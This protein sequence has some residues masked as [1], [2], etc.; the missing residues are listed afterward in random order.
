LPIIQAK[1]QGLDQVQTATGIGAKPDDVTGI[2]RN[3]GLKQ[4]DVEHFYCNL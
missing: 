3:L 2:G 4:D 1:T